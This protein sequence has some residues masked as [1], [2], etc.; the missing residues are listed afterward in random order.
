M[1]FS[2]IKIAK[3]NMK[4]KW[5]VSNAQFIL[6]QVNQSDHKE[7][8]TVSLVKSITASKTHFSTSSIKIQHQNKGSFY[9]KLKQEPNIKSIQ[10][11]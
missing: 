9:R 6:E 10:E 5:G 11:I 3:L 1:D 4:N 8:L 7:W 2:Q